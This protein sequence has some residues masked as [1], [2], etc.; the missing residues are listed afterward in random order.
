VAALR[1]A[2]VFLLLAAPAAAQQKE[3]LP[4]FVADVHGIFARHKSEPSVATELGVESGNLPTHSYGL[5]GGA[6]AY[7]LRG[8]R[9]ALGVGGTMLFAGGHDTIETT[10]AD[11]SVTK[12]P[13]VRRHF[14]SINP[15]ISLNFGHK[16]GWSYIS[17]GFGG[18]SRLYLDRED[19]PATDVP[20]RPTLT[21]GAGARWFATD[22][23]AFSVEVRW[24]SIAEQLAVPATNV[25]LEPRTTLMVLSG[26]IS[27]K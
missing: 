3:P 13:T 12:S 26:G 2:F 25:V 6:H 22:H 5:V 17:G 23:V 9:I 19:Q 10:N 11:G 4:P 20:L 1:A 27:I 14:R 24:Y 16:N 7:V 18:R 21:Y 15:E 8:R